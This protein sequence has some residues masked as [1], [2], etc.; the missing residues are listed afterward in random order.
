MRKNL[1]VSGNEYM[2]ADGVQIVSSTDPKGIIK[3][4]NPAFVEA[5]GFTEAELLGAPHNILRHPDMPEAAFKDLWDTVAAGKPWTGLV[6]NRRKNGDHYW[7]EAHV[8]PIRENG[9]TT[10]YLSVRRK[11]EH[12]QIAAAEALYKSI[13]E[14][15][16][17]LHAGGFKAM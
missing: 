12:A 11:P 8:T 17:S 14:G 16:G 6:K 13:R 1:P 9:Q 4:V 15:R 7:V 3:Q 5:S 10:G 2:L